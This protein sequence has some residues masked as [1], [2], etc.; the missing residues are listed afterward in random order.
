MILSYVEEVTTHS[1]K[2]NNL[3][4]PMNSFVFD[5]NDKAVDDLVSVVHTQY[6][7]CKFR[8]SNEF[9]FTILAAFV[10]V[11]TDTQIQADSE[12][13]SHRHFKVISL[14]TGS[15]CL[16]KSRLPPRGDALHDSHAEVLARRGL[17]RWLYE[18]IRRYHSHASTS[19]WIHRDESSGKFSLK[20]NVSLYM[21]ISTIPCKCVV[22]LGNLM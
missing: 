14:A 2:S 4:P 17:V 1:N 12:N 10:L 21:Y 19:E 11:H 7:K 3:T 8:P 20:H 16:P 22:I 6:A 15:K 5:N 18:E 9:Q 13:V